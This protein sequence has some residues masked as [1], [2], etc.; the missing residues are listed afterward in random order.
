MILP[1]A[2]GGPFLFGSLGIR[3]CLRG[4]YICECA[5][6]I[7]VEQSA[8]HPIL[9]L[10]LST[11]SALRSCDFSNALMEP[12]SADRVRLGVGEEA[13][14]GGGSC[15]GGGGVDATDEGT[16][17][18]SDKGAAAWTGTV[19]GDAAAAESPTLPLRLP[20]P[21]LFKM[22]LRFRSFSCARRMR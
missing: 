14:A 11:V 13:A 12:N 1:T 7:N 4:R 19:S 9:G 5:S 6:R 21:P 10:L 18:V 20:P 3:M 22:S 2:T 16:E 15:G 17:D 8:P